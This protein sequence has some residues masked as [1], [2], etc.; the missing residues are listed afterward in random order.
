MVQVLLDNIRS[1]Y[2][3]GSVF[4]TCDSAGVDELLLTGY[5]AIPPNPKLQK[6][7]LGSIN[8]VAWTH[9]CV[10]D[11]AVNYLKSHHIPIICFETAPNPISLFEYEFPASCCLVFGNEE[12]GIQPSTIALADAVVKIPQYGIKESLNIASAAAIAIY[13]YRRQQPTI[14]RI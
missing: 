4:R 7:A 13:E 14:T 11:N 10:T 1:A 8:N 12:L 5:C 9:H 3:V 6:T 2:N